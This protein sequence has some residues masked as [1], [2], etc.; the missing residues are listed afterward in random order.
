M[1][2]K[3]S[4]CLLYWYYFFFIYNIVFSPY[5]LRA[6]HA[7][8][9]PPHRKFPKKSPSTKT[10]RAVYLLYTTVSRI[11]SERPRLRFEVYGAAQ[12][13]QRLEGPVAPLPTPTLLRPARWWQSF[14]AFSL[15]PVPTIITSDHYSHKQKLIPCFSPTKRMASDLYSYSHCFCLFYRPLCHHAIVATHPIFPHNRSLMILITNRN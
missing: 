11:Y 3:N 9:F 4:Q 13:A 2:N 1:F 14:P 6:L 7:K 12:P 5:T 8:Y 15:L 10:R